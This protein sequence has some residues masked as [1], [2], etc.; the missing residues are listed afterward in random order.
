MYDKTNDMELIFCNNSVISYPLHNHI[1][2]FT[3]GLLINGSISLS[4]ANSPKLCEVNHAFVIL[5]YMPHTI[6]SHTSYTLL[7]LCINKHTVICCNREKLKNKI[8]QF[9]AAVPLLHLTE[10]QT[11]EFVNSIDF[12]SGFTELHFSQSCVNVIKSQLERFPEQPLSIAE[13]AHTAY[14][15]KYHFIRCFKKI[16]GLT[17]HQFQIQ[18]RVRKAQ[19][20][21]ND[22]DNITEVALTTGFCDQSHFIKLFKKYVG[23]TPAEYKTSFRLL[24]ADNTN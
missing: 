10:F 20:M 3:V 14:I 7:T 9:L 6:I 15:S 22:V 17:P 4:V 21:L 12:I 1:S 13:M 18:N 24:T 16:V 2:V 23:L 19:H 8:R 11:A 5:P